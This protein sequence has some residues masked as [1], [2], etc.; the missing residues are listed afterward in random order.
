MI[1]ITAEKDYERLDNFLVEQLNISRTKANKLIITR[2]VT[3]DSKGK[4]KPA[5]TVTSGQK[6]TV[7]LPESPNMTKLKPENVNFD[8]VY[9]DEHLLVINK[10]AGL[11]VHPAPGNWNH[12]LA[13]G[14]VYRYPE[15]KKLDNPMRPGIVH[16]LDSGTS[17]LM[18]AART[19]NMYLELQ[20]LFIERKVG[21]TYLALMHNSPKKLEGIL[22]GPIDRDPDNFM[23]MVIIE[24]GKPSLTGYKILWSMNGYSL[25][26][27]KLFT[28]RMHQ[29]RVHMSGHRIMVMNLREEFICILGD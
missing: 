2:H 5:S 3:R 29:I 27:C 14:L 9:E 12:T 19:Q 26:K 1:E 17:G 16:R 24:G 20:K 18:V 22:S 4:L 25:S 13:N 7:E 11:V 6:F 28:G 23:K 21:K 15:M 8:V 10:P